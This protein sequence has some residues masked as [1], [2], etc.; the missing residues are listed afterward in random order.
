MIN[1][2]GVVKNFKTLDTGTKILFL[3]LATASPSGEFTRRKRELANYLNVS[4]QTVGRYLKTYVDCEIL[5]FKYSGKGWVNPK[6]S[7]AGELDAFP[8]AVNGYEN[9]KSDM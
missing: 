6:F 1:V 4:E 5:K 3:I 7:Y 8:Q 2:K 9:F